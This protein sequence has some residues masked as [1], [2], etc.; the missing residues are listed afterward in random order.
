MK[1]LREEGGQ[2]QGRCFRRLGVPAGPVGLC[3]HGREARVTLLICQVIL[4]ARERLRAAV[5]EMED[6]A[7][8]GEHVEIGERRDWTGVCAGEGRARM[9]WRLASG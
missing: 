2:D 7:E 8:S 1:V 9:T 4:T 6:E 5:L 3:A